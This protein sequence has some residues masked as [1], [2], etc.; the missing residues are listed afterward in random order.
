LKINVLIWDFDGKK[1]VRRLEAIL[2]ERS[3]SAPLAALDA[4]PGQLMR[5]GVDFENPAFPPPFGSTLV[6]TARRPPQ[7]GAF[8]M[9]R[10]TRPT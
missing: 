8:D 9:G 2:D 7:G 4:T 10:A 3:K 5:L 1:A 6:A